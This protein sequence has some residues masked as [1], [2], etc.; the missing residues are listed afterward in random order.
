MTRDAVCHAPVE[1]GYTLRERHG[2]GIKEDMRIRSPRSLIPRRIRARVKDPV[3]LRM[4]S[5]QYGRLV[6]DGEEVTG[7]HSIE[8]QSLLWSE[9]GTRLAAHELVSWHDAPK[10]RVVVFDTRRRARIA[11]SRPRTGLG[12]PVRFESGVLIYRHWHQK[13]ERELRLIIDES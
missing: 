13:G 3:E 9:D 12:D 10:T 11:A 1:V 4:G 6:L 5:P 2:S 7:A 8:S